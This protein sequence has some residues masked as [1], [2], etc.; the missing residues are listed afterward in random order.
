MEALLR[1]PTIRHRVASAGGL[2]DLPESTIA[3]LAVFAALHDIGK[4]NVGFQCRIW[5]RVDGASL[6][7]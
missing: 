4:A 6:P 3:R 7:P 2:D 1:Q 5:P